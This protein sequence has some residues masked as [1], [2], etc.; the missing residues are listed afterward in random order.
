MFYSSEDKI[1]SNQLTSQRQGISPMTEESAIKQE[2]GAVVIIMSD[3]GPEPFIN[4]SHLDENA[5]TYLA[6]KGFTAFM[7]GFET[8]NYGPGKIRGILQIPATEC[9]AIAIDINLRGSGFETDERLQV[10]RNG[11][12]CLVANEEQ[13]A[14]VRKF[15]TQTEV[16][17]IEK[18]K[19]ITTI[20]HLNQEFCQNL[21][22][23]YNRF[24]AS[25][26]KSEEE[27]QAS[28]TI[29]NSLFEVG[30]LLSLP[31]DENL[32][33]RIIM[34]HSTK[35][36]KGITLE[37]IRRLTKRRRKEEQ[38]II[39]SLLA[40]GLIFAIAPKNKNEDICYIAQ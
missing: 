2:F 12:F 37:A 28:K 20:N 39:N 26:L 22:V 25:L 30:V 27:K 10:N 32:T 38:R 6:I 36:K 3:L 29:C 11:V 8:D 40:K 5:A 4:I 14:L 1:E 21:L 23:D 24:L 15:Y 9:F 18:L 33:A 35:E 19:A 31:K 7:T 16:F 13:L 34:E 17:L